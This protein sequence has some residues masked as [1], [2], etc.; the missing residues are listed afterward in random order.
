MSLVV[1]SA[2]A[3]LLEVSIEQPKITVPH[4]RKIRTCQGRDLPLGINSPILVLNLLLD[5]TSEINTLV[6]LIRLGTG[7]TD[8][9]LVV[10]VLCHL[11]PTSE[12]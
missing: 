5:E 10:K 4:L 8:P 2:T 6:K 9:A 11:M 1:V 7:V 3:R 12:Y